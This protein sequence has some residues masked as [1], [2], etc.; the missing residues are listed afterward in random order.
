MTIYRMATMNLVIRSFFVVLVSVASAAIIS[1]GCSDDEPCRPGALAPTPDPT[2]EN[3][4]PNE[5]GTAWTFELTERTWNAAF[6]DSVFSTAEDVPPAPSIEEVV[7]LLTS[8]AIGDSMDSNTGIYRLKFDGLVTTMSGVTAQNLRTWVFEEAFGGPGKEVTTP[9]SFLV[10]LY[11]ARPDLRK[12]IL[13]HLQSNLAAKA[14]LD[15]SEGD[16]RSLA[17]SRLSARELL[18]DLSFA[19]LLLHGY[20]WAKTADWIGGYGDID[21][22]LAWKFLEADLAPGANFRFQLLPSVADDIY[23]HALVLSQRSVTTE[24]GTFEKC[25]ECLY[26]IDYGVS[27]LTDNTGQEIGFFRTFDYGT[28]VYAPTIGPVSS[29]ERRFVEP[30]DPP[31]PG[32]GDLRL[33]LVG[34]NARR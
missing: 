24:L 10:R 22:L 18:A 15:L 26:M 11:Q 7:T 6:P 31:T 14:V 25:V 27:G 4:W 23:L 9:S 13:R 3:V 2:L 29:Y 16:I 28:I 5:D 12:K 32:M 20:A 33:S 17:G 21:T 8:H 19:P 1:L 30:L 34:T